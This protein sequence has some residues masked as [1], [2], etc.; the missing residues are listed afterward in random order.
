MS[1]ALSKFTD[2]AVKLGMKLLEAE[3][4]N[5]VD[6]PKTGG[7]YLLENK[8][9]KESYV[10]KAVNLYRRA[11]SDHI[12]GDYDGSTSTFRRKLNNKHNISFGKVM[13]SHVLENFN[14]KFV[15]IDDADMR[16]LVE[17]LVICVMR[18][19]GV[20]LLNS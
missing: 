12:S 10:G 4:V 13:R 1:Q 8:N 20:D 2:E 7:V 16:S 18:E 14:F 11:N 15:Q 19:K 6:F 17:G 5:P 3:S 9:G